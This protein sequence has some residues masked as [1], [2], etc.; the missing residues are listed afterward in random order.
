MKKNNTPNEENFIENNVIISVNNLLK[1]F[2]DCT[3]VDNLTFDINKGEVFGLLGPNGA[4][5]TSFLRMVQCISPRTG[6]DL[7]VFGLDPDKSH[8]SI[9]RLL[10]IVPQENNL[11][12]ELSVYEN[13]IQYA[14]F[15][16][17]KG[18]IAEEKAES[19]L[20]MIELTDKRNSSIDAISGGMKRRLVLARALVNDPSLLILDEPT[21]GLD[22]QARHFIWDHVRKFRDEGNTVLL[23]T[24]YLEEAERLCDRLLI[25]DNGHILAQGKPRDVIE[26]YAG[27]YV[28]ILDNSEREHEILKANSLPFTPMGSELYHF[29]RNPQPVMKIFMNEGVTDI[30]SRKATLEDVFLVITGRSLRD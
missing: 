16:G 23:T 5:K 18:R 15:F 6:G 12:P 19:L 26:N 11:D 30:I 9:K 20:K 3:A 29:T 2:G 17:I 27:E 14:R 1:K 7:T 24:H 22:P 28:V 10:G 4:G 8:I 21:T 13:L 25:I